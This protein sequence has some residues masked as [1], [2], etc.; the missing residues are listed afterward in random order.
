VGPACTS[1]AVISRVLRTDT[2]KS[3]NRGILFI[4]LSR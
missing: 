3:E 1:D 2:L 4:L